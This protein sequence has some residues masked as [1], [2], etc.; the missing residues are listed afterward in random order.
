M[1]LARSCLCLRLY[2]AAKR[3][4]K[5]YFCFHI[6]LLSFLLAG[7]ASKFVPVIL[8]V[9]IKFSNDEWKIFRITGISSSITS[10]PMANNWSVSMFILIC[11]TAWMNSSLYRESGMR[12]FWIKL[13][14]IIRSFAVAE[15]FSK[16]QSAG[17]FMPVLKHLQGWISQ[18]TM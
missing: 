9:S 5:C 7:Q 18:G 6:A 2:F 3:F 14:W 4:R 10:L 16:E 15:I 1:L 12:Y 17:L 13:T 8:S 11:L